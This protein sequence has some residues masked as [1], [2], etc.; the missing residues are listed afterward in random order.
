MKRAQI[1]RNNGK[2]RTLCFRLPGGV[3]WTVI[4][5]H[6]VPNVCLRSDLGSGIKKEK[7]ITFGFRQTPAFANSTER[8]QVL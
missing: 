2:R 7:M 6:A 3:I 1:I 8:I 4:S 5:G